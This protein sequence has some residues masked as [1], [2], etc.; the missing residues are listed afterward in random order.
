MVLSWPVNRKS[1]DNNSAPVEIPDFTRG[2]WQKLKG[3]EF[4]KKNKI[5]LKENFCFNRQN[6]KS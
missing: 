3:L 1:L 5:N 6:P 2:G 4:S